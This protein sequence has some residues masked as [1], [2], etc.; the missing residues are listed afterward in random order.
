M[1]GQIE[2]SNSQVFINKYG[3]A[4]AKVKNNIRV[5][6]KIVIMCFLLLPGVCQ[7]GEVTFGSKYQIPSIK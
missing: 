1:N 4:I 2:H 6:F 3:C 5:V 7:I